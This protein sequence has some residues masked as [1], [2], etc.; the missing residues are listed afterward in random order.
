MGITRNANGSSLGGQ[1]IHDRHGLSIASRFKLAHYP[2]TP[3][4]TGRHARGH[5]RPRQCVC[6]EE[7]PVP[8]EGSHINQGSDRATIRVPNS[9]KYAGES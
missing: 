6:P 9:V 2:P 7:C 3:P 4:Y 5:G 1:T 8:I